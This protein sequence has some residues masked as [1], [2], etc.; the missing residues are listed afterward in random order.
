MRWIE[1][2][3]YYAKE[4]NMKLAEVLDDPKAKEEYEKQKSK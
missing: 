3:V 2:I 1:F 4:N